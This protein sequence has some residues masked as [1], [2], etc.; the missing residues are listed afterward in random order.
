MKGGLRQLL[1]PISAL[2]VLLLVMTLL[3]GNYILAVTQISEAEL[4]ENMEEISK[5]SASTIAIQISSDLQTLDSLA[6]YISADGE[7]DPTAVAD[8]LSRMMAMERFK[9]TGIITPDGI[10]HTS[11]G[12]TLDF[13]QR[14]YFRAGM[15][16]LSGVT[17]PLSDIV[18]SQSINVYYVPIWQGDRVTSVLFA[19][20]SSDVYKEF[21]E[22]S[23]FGGQ[24]Y[25]YLV[26]ANGDL[27]VDTSHPDSP[28]FKNI[29]DLL[30]RA[31]LHGEGS[32]QEMQEKLARQESG[33]LEF[34]HGGETL[35]L[36]YQPLGMGDW[37]VLSLVPLEAVN[38]KS[39]LLIQMA[40]G[41]GILILIVFAFLLFYI[42]DRQRRIQGRLEEAAYQDTLID[43][44]NWNSF[45]T[46]APK[47]LGE[48]SQNDYAIVLLDVD[49]FKVINDLYGQAVGNDT[50]Q[51][52]ART[53]RQSLGEKELFCRVYADNFVMLLRFLG[54]EDCVRRIVQLSRDINAE[55]P[56]RP[57]LINYGI[58]VISD[59]NR[60]I[61]RCYDRAILAKNTV[62]GNHEQFYAFYDGATRDKILEEKEIEGEMH[63]A[64]E[65]RQFQVYLQPK[66]HVQT[67]EIR[68]AEALVR[69]IHPQ[70]GTISPG[71]FIPLFERNHFIT[72]L[73]FYV[74]EEVVRTLR[75]WM[76]RGLP[77]MP[78]SV[79][80][81]RLNL[82]TPDLIGRLAQIAAAHGVEPRW[83]EI[84][85]TE[86][87]VFE[88]NRD[89]MEIIEQIHAAGFTISVD[90]F[91]SG[92][93]SLNLLKDLMFD[94]IKLDQEFLIPSSDEGR[95]YQLVCSIIE[96]VQGLG[97][98]TVAEGVEDEAQLALI[99][100]A[101]C[102]LAQGYYFS[103]PIPIPA[104]EALAFPKE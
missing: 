31:E 94:V 11:D 101:G 68:G 54:E 12:L 53:I 40:T 18:D 81:S 87:A 62:K 75:S 104:F 78:V 4:R 102:E 60:E 70:R 50:L 44:P 92:Y 41:C 73:D 1:I 37:T 7:Q 99:R 77:L 69:W 79:N 74:F 34:S 27:V 55:F 39:S 35:C 38:Q 59:Q 63:R 71:S 97:M 33:S 48:D 85:I 15:T 30:S 76:D 6:C 80:I 57:L 64:L 3:I 72:R 5:Q 51:Q 26:G 14:A 103:R 45:R 95:S 82:H 98:H 2:L 36:R 20:I 19:T 91:G 93:S 89:L 25:A 32:L 56:A 84:E 13:S 67:G 88:L 28:S 22:T 65:E 16:G 42:I 17:D 29:F 47:V 52:I 8:S 46:F 21:L 49:K 86:S 10:A 43:G 66:N 9:R 90:D 83:L 96:L 23:A 100:Q 61:S 58:Y 24:G